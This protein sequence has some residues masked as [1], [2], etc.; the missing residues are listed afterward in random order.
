MDG[1]GSRLWG[2]R[3]NSPGIGPI[4]A[5]ENYSAALLELL[6][7]QGNLSAL[8]DF[9]YCSIDVPDFVAVEDSGFPEEKLEGASTTA[10]GDKWW[11][12]GQFALLRVP[13]AVTRVESNFLINPLHAEYDHIKP[14]EPKPVWMDPRLFTLSA[15]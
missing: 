9:H 13:S 8:N 4:Y 11:K 7:N 3:W 1:T 10:I 15:K 2:G 5:A 6:V 14:S 12:A